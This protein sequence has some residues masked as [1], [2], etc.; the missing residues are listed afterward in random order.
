MQKNDTMPT[1]DKDQIPNIEEVLLSAKTLK[2]DNADM[3]KYDTAS[4][5][6]F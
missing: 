3:L 6:H 1:N 2:E 5:D 4:I